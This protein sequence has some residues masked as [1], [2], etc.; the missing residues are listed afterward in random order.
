M[1]AKLGGKAGDGLPQIG[2]KSGKTTIPRAAPPPVKMTDKTR[3]AT[4]D[5]AQLVNIDDIPALFKTIERMMRGLR[6][7]NAEMLL[8]M[9]SG[10]EVWLVPAYTQEPG[11]D[12]RK[13]ISFEDAAKITVLCASFGGT[14]E[15]LRFLSPEE[16]VTPPEEP[17]QD[18]DASPPPPP[19]PGA[20]ASSVKV[21]VECADPE[22]PP[23]DGPEKVDT[24]NQGSLFS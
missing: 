9:G 11:E 3:P 24:K 19:L 14:V 22:D 17:E 8:R 16:R 15:S 4:V 18:D 12:G 13:E 5:P 21:S 7:L 6:D 2:G 10:E 23:K 1:S 20:S